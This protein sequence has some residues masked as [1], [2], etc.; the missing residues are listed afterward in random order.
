MKNFLPLLLISFLFLSCTSSKKML[1]RGQYDRAIER[2]TEKLMKKP[3]NS[4]E[5][6]VLEEAY[7]LAN[8][9][10]R[11]RIE[12]LEL[13]GREESWVEIYQ[14]YEQL[15]WRQNKV[16][17]LPS[18]IRNRFTFYNYDQEIIESKS[19]AA[20]ISY[21]RGLEFLEK[22]DKLSARQAFYEFETAAQIYPGYE[23]VDQNMEQSLLRGANYALFIIENNSGMILPE[24]FDAELKKVSLRDQSSQWVVFDT[25]ENESVDYDYFVTLNITDINFSPE[26]IEQKTYT[27]SNEIEDGLRYELDENGNVRKDSLGNDIQVPNLVTVTAE[28]TESNQSKSAFVAGSLDF[29]ELKSDQLI[30][31]D[32]IA[33]EAVFRHQFGTYTGNR[34]ALSEESMKIIR[35]REI[36]FQSN[37]SM[38]M[39]AAELLKDRAVTIITRNRRLLEG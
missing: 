17:R 23:N 18:Q 33:V 15:N 29:Y 2:S 10:D 32:N 35:G 13:E 31:T 25:Y 6:T 20:D 37:E 38:L 34:K 28:V 9:F 21:K 39:N 3:S 14:L 16:R 1:E 11:E 12:F 24:Y 19:A 8:M 30:R 7:E 27:E 4:K 26:R 36:P 22:G 5:L